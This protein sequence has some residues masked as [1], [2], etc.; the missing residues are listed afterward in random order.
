MDLKNLTADQKL[1]L[2]QAILFKRKDKKKEFP[3]Y[4]ELANA[5]KLV[6][7]KALER[8]YGCTQFVEE[9]FSE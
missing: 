1:Q 7:D 3:S 9:D 5:G 4:E 6:S 2:K 8:E